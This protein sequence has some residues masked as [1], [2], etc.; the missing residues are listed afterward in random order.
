MNGKPA[1]NLVIHEI[2]HQ[3]FGDAITEKDWDEVWLSEGF[4][5]YFTLLATE[6]YEGRDAFVA[7]LGRAKE[8]VAAAQKQAPEQPIIH[9]N[10][11]EMSKVLNRLVYQKGAWVLHMLRGEM[12][13][14]PFWAG[15]RDYYAQYRDRNVSTDEFRAVMERRHGRNLQWFFDQWLHRPGWPVLEGGWRYDAASKKLVVE[16]E[17][18]QAAEV[19][20]LPLELAI[21][22]GDSR[23]IERLEMNEKRQRFEIALEKAPGPAVVLDPNV[24]M[25]MDA[26]F[27][28]R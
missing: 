2:A 19:Y 13:T 15:I 4:A 11:G 6:H 26:R 23:R 9:R 20:R 24:W 25:L 3:W 12:G 27:E 22:S 8:A 10:L 1:T 21:G 7:G 16:L 28:A 17:Q 18:R 14:E 5:T